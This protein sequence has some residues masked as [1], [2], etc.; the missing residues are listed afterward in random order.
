M[1]ER[2]IPVNIDGWEDG[3]ATADDAP[4]V[5]TDADADL[6]QD[7]DQDQDQVEGDAD[8]GGD[9][10]VDDGPVEALPYPTRTDYRI[11]GIQPDFWPN[12]DEISGN[13]TGGVAMNLVWT[14]WEPEVRA[15]PCDPATQ[16]EHD[17]RCFVIDSSVDAAIRGW[18]ERGVVVTAIVYGVPEWARVGNTR[19][20]PVAP[21]FEIFC[22]PD[23]PS[24][25]GRFAGML[26]S[27]YDGRHGNGRIADF[28]IHNE[29]NANDWFDI[30]CGGG[31]PCDR[32][33]WVR[34]YADNY[35]AAYD[36]V[37]AAQ[38]TA[39]VLISFE[40]H[41]DTEFDRPGADHP[42][43]S[44]RTFLTQLAPHL[45]DRQW[46]VAYHPYAPNLFSP[47]FSADDLP[48]VTYG[49]IGVL[50][51][52]LRATFPHDPHAWEVHLT[53][54]GISSAPPQSSEEAQAVAVC[55]TL[56]NVLGTPGIANYIYH[57]MRDHPG[58]GGLQLGLARED[59][60]LKP[61]WAVWALA[62]RIDLEPPQL[63]CGFEDLPHV[64]L[65]RGYNPARGH[66][67]SSRLLPPGFAE[68]HSWL[69]LRN[70]APGTTLLFECE[71]GGH[72]F[73]TDR[74]DCEGQQ[75]MGPVGYI[76]DTEQPDTVPLF[77]CRIGGG[78]DH[79]VSSHAECEGQTVERLLGYARR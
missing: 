14:G 18:T 41:F 47:V 3:D 76:F 31:S 51:G 42:L 4:A 1:D 29:V 75:P 10:D 8:L 32:D 23:H 27:R 24:D 62:N 59:G 44:V 28:V 64:R 16:Q 68:E 36:A 19:C 77:R 45:G 74:P 30:G 21:G 78:R 2:C 46:Q 53:E 63:S 66:W 69:L 50:L 7:Q 39:K 72:N 67:A 17:G 43:L 54:S 25:Y 13:N 22:A 20:S 48:R 37:V 57:R 5:D 9:V 40:H 73:L 34:A 61:A 55:D 70:E 56:R 71:V 38:P 52:W 15:P 49:N 33:A 79:F 6:D 65:R 60:T 58:E 11:K 26:A 35:N 12:M